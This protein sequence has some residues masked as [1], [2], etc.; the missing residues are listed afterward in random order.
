MDQDDL[1][2]YER[3][4][5]RVETVRGF[6]SHALVFVMVNLGLVVYN[7][8][9]EP[10]RLWFVFT[11]GGWGI[12]LM[13]HGLYVASS[14]RFMGQAWEDRKIGEEMERDRS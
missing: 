11:L 14:G 12:G 8:A 6:Y 2:R 5:R 3:A 7:L 10:N 9:T 4:K 1:E 13:A